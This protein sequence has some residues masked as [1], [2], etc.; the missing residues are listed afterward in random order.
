[1]TFIFVKYVKKVFARIVKKR[2]KK[3]VP[4]VEQDTLPLCPI[5]I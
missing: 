5:Q 3:I 1:M 4:T 2:G